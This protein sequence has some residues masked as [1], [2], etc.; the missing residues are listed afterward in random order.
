MTHLAQ[1]LQEQGWQPP[2]K[3]H[4]DYGGTRIHNHTESLICRTVTNV[5]NEGD[6]CGGEIEVEWETHYRVPQRTGQMVCINCNILE[7]AL[8]VTGPDTCESFEGDKV[9]HRFEPEYEEVDEEFEL[10]S[11][12]TYCWH[13]LTKEQAM[14]MLNDKAVE[15]AERRAEQGR[16]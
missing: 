16:V 8:E 4:E 5:P 11:Y 3:N 2:R 7:S 9:E 6:E 10:I 15:Y 1:W 12:K 13:P 14:E